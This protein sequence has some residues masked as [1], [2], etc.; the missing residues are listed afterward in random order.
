MSAGGDRKQTEKLHRERTKP[1]RPGKPQYHGQGEAEI[2]PA[3][4]LKAIL[5]PWIK[6]WNKQYPTDRTDFEGPH[7]YLSRES[8]VPVRQISRIVNLE[9]TSVSLSDADAI[10]Q[11]LERPDYLGNEI[12]VVP[13]PNW[14]LERWMAYMEERGCI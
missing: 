6:K 2:V 5:D 11:A 1:A 4:Q 14:S 3:Y 8:G 9:I 10:L 7:G 13:N 12:Q